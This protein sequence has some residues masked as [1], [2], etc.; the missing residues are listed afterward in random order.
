MRDDPGPLPAIV[1][2]VLSLTLLVASYLMSQAPQ[3]RQPGIQSTAAY[4][5]VSCTSY[6]GTSYECP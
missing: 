2:V 3:P 6:L 4:G 1:L 5:S